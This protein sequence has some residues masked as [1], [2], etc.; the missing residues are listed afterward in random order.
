[1]EC[2]LI[3]Y[4]KKQ[5]LTNEKTKESMECIESIYNTSKFDV[6]ICKCNKCGQKFIYCFKEYNSP[7]W[8]DYY[9]S[10]WIKASEEDII[11][12][13]NISK[14]FEDNKLKPS[15]I[16]KNVFIAPA[17]L[18]KLIYKMVTEK[19]HIVW[20]D[21]NKFYWVEKGMAKYKA[22]IIFYGVLIKDQI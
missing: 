19:S 16:I 21:D 17:D 22:Q 5:R 13:K 4:A 7:H 18:K 6:S 20:A 15:D 12:I 14:I 3:E 11:G 9:W 2:H 1:M 8:E 10:F